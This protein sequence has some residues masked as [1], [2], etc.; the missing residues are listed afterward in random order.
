MLSFP[1]IEAFV[2]GKPLQPE[3]KLDNFFDLTAHEECAPLQMHNKCLL[4]L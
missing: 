3:W 2:P 4:V 1:T